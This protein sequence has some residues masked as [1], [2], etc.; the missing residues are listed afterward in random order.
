MHT[1]HGPNVVTGAVL[2][3]IAG[4]HVGWGLGFTW[5]LRDTASLSDTVVG[6]DAVPPP[7]AC[8][9]VAGAL[10]AA[11]ALVSGWPR[12]HP[13]ARA[14]GRAGV[15]AVLTTRGVVGVLRLTEV[16]S[17]GS[18]SP[19]FQRWDRRLYSPLCLLL[20]A[21]AARSVATSRQS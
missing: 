17:P 13:V 3:G 15:A 19:R 2:A 6:S 14:L 8:F 16:V 9:A 4:L 21:G 5:P 10:G 7:A 18:V 11:A 1:R 12:R 20:A